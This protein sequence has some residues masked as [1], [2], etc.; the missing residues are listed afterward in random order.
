MT[1]SLNLV[2]NCSASFLGDAVDQP[3]AELRE[4]AADR[5]LGGVAERV[6]SPPGVSVTRASPFAKPATPPWPSKISV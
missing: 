2:K 3:R 5:R 1:C 6:L 4:F